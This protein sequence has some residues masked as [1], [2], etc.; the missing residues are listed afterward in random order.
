MVVLREVLGLSYAEIGEVAGLD[1][2]A[3]TRL[4][5]VGRRHLADRLIPRIKQGGCLK[6]G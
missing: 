6:K 3:V 5:T 1:E 4:L 2:P